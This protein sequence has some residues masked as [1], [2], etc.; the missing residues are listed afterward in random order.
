MAFFDYIVSLSIRSAV[1]IPV[2]VLVRTLLKKYPKRYS[3]FVWIIVFICLVVKIDIPAKIETPAVQ[4]Q[5]TIQQQYENVMNSYTGDIK[6]YQEN[7][8]EYH[9]A[10]QQGVQPI[11]SEEGRYVITEKDTYAPPATVKS[12][13]MPKVQLVWLAG[14]AVLIIVYVKNIV[15]ITSALKF[16]VPYKYDIYYSEYITTPFVFGIIK[17]KIYLP[18]SITKEQAEAVVSHER[19]HIKRL[20]Y[21]VK[22]LC[23]FIT[24]LHWFNP[25]VWIAFYLMAKDMEQSCDE[26]VVKFYDSNGK[27]EYCNALM[28]FAIKDEQYKIGKVMFGE[29]DCSNRIKNILSDKYGYKLIAEILVL[30]VLSTAIG[31]TAENSIADESKFYNMTYA[32]LEE[33]QPQSDEE[34]IQIARAM[35]KIPDSEISSYMAEKITDF[36]EKDSFAKLKTVSVYQDHTQ[37]VYN[38]SKKALCNADVKIELELYPYNN[39]DIKTQAEDYCRKLYEHLCGEYADG[40]FVPNLDFV[41][42]KVKSFNIDVYSEKHEHIAGYEISANDSF[43][44]PSITEKPTEWVQSLTQIEQNALDKAFVYGDKIFV[45]K[46]FGIKNVNELY[47]EYHI[48]DDYFHKGE[49]SAEDKISAQTA[50][51]NDKYA[52]ITEKVINDIQQYIEQNNLQTAVVAFSHRYLENGKVEFEV[53][54]NKDA[55]QFT[56]DFETEDSLAAEKT[57][58]GFIWPTEK[59]GVH[60][61]RGF[62]GEYPAHDGLDIAGAQGTEIYAAAD[63]TVNISAETTDRYGNYIVILHNDGYRTL[64]AHCDTLLVKTGETVKQG[65]LIATM[66]STGNSTGNHLHFGISK[67]FE[68]INTEEFLNSYPIDADCENCGGQMIVYNESFGSWMPSGQDYCVHGYVFGTDLIMERGYIKTTVCSEC[69]FGDA[70]LITETKLECHGH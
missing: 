65:Q 39:V 30:V 70:E 14:I 68:Y 15:D 34:K 5:Q 8:E 67:D 1:V 2:A 23:F 59:T 61:S 4:A 45:L 69:N 29:N 47:I 28:Q 12:S 22:P 3:Y 55:P 31:C 11:I 43:K 25:L 58:S 44:N 49:G 18:Y 63:G 54:L 57:P 7:T 60:V 9:Q 48:E 27:K 17:P 46:N 36:C 32:E 13:F 62:S 37:L 26:A 51:L 56:H 16:A 40:L 64:Y 52:D 10:V 21:I 42:H 50:A 53:V 33:Y 35:D 24:A 20:D 41:I 38:D 19:V 6:I 66:G